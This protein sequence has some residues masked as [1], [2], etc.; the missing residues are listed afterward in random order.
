MPSFRKL[1]DEQEAQLGDAQ[2]RQGLVLAWVRLLMSLWMRGRAMGLSLFGGIFLQTTDSPWLLVMRLFKITFGSADEPS[3][4][5]LVSPNIVLVTGLAIKLRNPMDIRFGVAAAA[6]VFE[7]FCVWLVRLGVAE[8]SIGTR[9]GLCCVSDVFGNE[10][11]P[12]IAA[13]SEVDIEDV[14]A[15]ASWKEALILAAICEDAADDDTFR[16]KKPNGSL[17]A[18][19]ESFTEIGSVASKL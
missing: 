7:L 12:S 2:I 19:L 13:A 17:A 9:T 18:L 5:T 11:G 6:A 14:K 15:E 8:F 4:L 16:L 1:V 10:D 3:S